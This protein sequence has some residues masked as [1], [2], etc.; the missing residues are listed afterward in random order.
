MNTFNERIFIANESEK[1]VAKIV[2]D[3]LAI[4][5]IDNDIYKAIKYIVHKDYSFK[6]IKI[7]SIDVETND[8]KIYL[9]ILFNYEN[10]NNNVQ[11]SYNRTLIVADIDEE[12][13][14]IS[15]INNY[16]PKFFV[17]SRIIEIYN[18][19]KEN[20]KSMDDLKEILSP[21]LIFEINSN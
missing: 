11:Y 10:Q 15:V 7:K 1:I 12:N 4:N 6:N 19:L 14:K 5:K 2:N 21:V 16:V 13:H 20:K 9:N 8:S 3:I 17:Q 18:D